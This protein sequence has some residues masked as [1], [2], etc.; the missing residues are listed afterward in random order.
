MNSEHLA[1]AREELEYGDERPS[2]SD[3]GESRY[4]DEA[5][6]DAIHLILDGKEW[7]AETLEI[8]AEIVEQSG[9]HIR[10]LGEIEQDITCRRPDCEALIVEY[11]ERDDGDVDYVCS[12]GHATAEPF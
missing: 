3:I 12:K 5:A 2:P 6:L 7:E 4:T 1:R 9:R 8:I 11:K 10:T